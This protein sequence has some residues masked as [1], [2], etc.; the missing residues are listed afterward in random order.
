MPYFD[1]HCHPGLKP[2]F[3]DPATKPSPWDFINAS[4]AVPV[5]KKIGI[6]GLFNEVL[7]SQSSLT[8][9]SKETSII[10]LVL[11]APESNMM[12]S[13]AVKKIT[14]GNSIKLINFKRIS[15]ISEGT[16]NYQLLQEELNHL[17]KSQPKVLGGK[18]IV[19]S[20]PEDFSEARLNT[21]YGVIIIEGLH[22]FFDDPTAADSKQAFTKNFN[23]FTARH[24][25]LAI[26]LCHIQQNPFCNHAHGI[27]FFNNKLFYP[28]G[29]SI[30]EWGK[31][32]IAMMQAKKILADTK[33]MSLKARLKLYEL[34]RDENNDKL[35][36]QPILCTHA[37]VTGLSIH[38]RGKYLY[39]PPL[40]IDN[41]VYEVAFLKP[42]S[43][44][45]P[46]T[47][48]NCSSINLY[49]EDIEAI[50]RSGGL[51][52]LSFDQRILG[53][54][55]ENVLK[56]V[57]VPHDVEYISQQEA[58][59]FLGP[60]PTQLPIYTSNKNI[61]LPEDFENVDASQN[62]DLHLDFFF[63]NAIHILQVAK[64]KGIGVKQAAKQMCLGTDFDGLINAIDCCKTA[65][66][67][68]AFKRDAALRLPVLLHQAKL[69]NEGIDVPE[70]LEDLFYRNGRDFVLQ[71]LDVM[72][73]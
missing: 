29:N 64:N 66:M 51:I 12:K 28:T 37:G 72:Q 44:H 39:K 67:F 7:N 38:E 40:K 49:D 35:Y 15:F 65:T 54:A 57:T 11:H 55:N 25:V 33:H 13:L 6:N 21:V 18:L 62:E 23:E 63:N 46:G 19:L 30:S 48:Y 8:Q 53:F 17:V 61:W 4:I 24:T 36:T 45:I 59:F 3:S 26:N 60:N 10:G 34:L 27:Q 9:L 73:A 20:K 2:Q 43:Q 5:L 16:H 69:D 42:A 1:F 50:L 22:C 71:R 58:T 47:Y 32:V 70:F 52:G 68:P 31:E 14:Q 41:D 56:A